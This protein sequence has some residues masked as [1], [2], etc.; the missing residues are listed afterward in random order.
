[1]NLAE[2]EKEVAALTVEEQRKLLG[3]LVQLRNRRDPEYRQELAERMSDK[4]PGHW[5]TI[6]EMEKR[7]GLS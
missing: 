1:M 2:I 3:Y 6:G 4:D 7:L 5:L